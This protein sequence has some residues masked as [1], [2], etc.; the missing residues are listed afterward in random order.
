MTA[1]DTRRCFSGRYA[2]SSPL[3]FEDFQGAC[4]DGTFKVRDVGSKGK[5]M[6][7]ELV[8]HRTSETFFFHYTFGMT[9][10]WHMNYGDTEMRHAVAVFQWKR[11]PPASSSITSSSVKSMSL[12]DPRR[13]GTV[14]FVS[15]LEHE[16]KLAS[17]GPDMLVAP[18]SIED[19]VKI[20]QKRRASNKQIA[21]AL[22]DQGLVSGVGNYIRA[23]A[24]YR[25]RIDPFALTCDVSSESLADLRN[26]TVAVMLESYALKGATLATYATVDGEV[27]GFSKFLRVYG[28]KVDPEGRPVEKAE[29]ADGRTIWFVRRNA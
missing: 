16:A 15:D 28:K 27:G 26:H 6:W 17:I 11:S 23:E 13:F 29:T 21:V 9:G 3:G 19:F 1:S 20:F 2:N 4:G 8:A 10:R 25:A 12:V 7:W 24:L 22:M 5:F 14:K 18:P